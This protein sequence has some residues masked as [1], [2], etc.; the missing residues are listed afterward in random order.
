MPCDFGTGA[1][2][3]DRQQGRSDIRWMSEISA[4]YSIFTFSEYQGYFY[5][6]AYK[7]I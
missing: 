1:D 2:N 5:N 6:I 7:R 4:P 3:R